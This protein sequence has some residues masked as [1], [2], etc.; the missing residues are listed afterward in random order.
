MKSDLLNDEIMQSLKELCRK[1]RVRR[2][3]IFGSV[4]RGDFNPDSDLDF[5]V[6]FMELK[7]GEY[8]DTYFGLLEELTAVFNRRVDL[9][10]SKAV[11]NPYFLKNIESSR[12]LLYAA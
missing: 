12:K 7:P 6:E 1:Y 5:M 11:K 3:E 4:A 10:M 9:V 8:A 2:L